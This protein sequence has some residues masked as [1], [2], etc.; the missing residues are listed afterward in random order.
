[1]WSAAS[2]LEVLLLALTVNRYVLRNSNTGNFPLW[3]LLLFT[4][5]KLP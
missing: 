4:F 3:L 1:M 2:L 5:N